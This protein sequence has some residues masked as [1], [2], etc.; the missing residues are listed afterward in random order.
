[1]F[2]WRAKATSKSRSDQQRVKALVVA[3]LGHNPDVGV[4]VNEI[5]CNDP[6]C[7]GQET[8]ILV[9]VP[10]KK[11]AATKISKAIVDVTEDDVRDA[12]KR[13]TYAP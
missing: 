10:K 3:A 7:P 13:L 11:T 6:G 5:V 2:T 8:V 1:M 9:M 12:L 4:S